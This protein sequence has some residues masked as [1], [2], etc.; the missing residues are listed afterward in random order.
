MQPERS[1][2]T[3]SPRSR[4]ALLEEVHLREFGGRAFLKREDLYGPA[5]GNKVRRFDAFFGDRP[6]M[7]RVMGLS[8][9]GAHTFHVLKE[10]L[11]DESQ[12]TG[13]DRLLF[14]ERSVEITPYA[15]RLREGYA[16]N[17]RIH[18]SRA[19]LSTQVAKYMVNR[20]L[21]HVPSV[22]I[23]GSMHLSPNPFADAMRET[24]HQLRARGAG[25]NA[26]HLFA[27]ASGTMADGFLEETAFTQTK[28]IAA[29]TGSPSTRPF[30]RSRYRNLPG[31]TLQDP[32]RTSWG[33]YKQLASRFHDQ[34]G[35]WLDPT[36]TI[37]LLELLR[38]PVVQN[39]RNIVLWITCPR[40][41]FDPT[42]LG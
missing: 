33:E 22:G 11:A 36:H 20:Y 8:D 34:T 2:Y 7:T 21:L 39:S 10:Y 4:E 24:V 1:H 18:V 42:K 14:L 9:P 17:P 31:L 35:V 27:L 15:A 30:V 29:L 3:L 13:T 26:A 41:D 16:N 40:I 5:G 23:G 25:A 19:P 32:P 12:N 37:H 28:L 38:N 6:R